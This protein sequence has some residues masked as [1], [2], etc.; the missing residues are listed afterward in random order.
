MTCMPLHGVHSF[1]FL[2]PKEELVCSDCAFLLTARYL[3][4]NWPEDQGASDPTPGLH[5]S[6][7]EGGDLD[8]IRQTSGLNERSHHIT[9]LLLTCCQT[10]WLQGKQ[11]PALHCYVVKSTKLWKIWS[12]TRGERKH[13]VSRTHGSHLCE[14]CCLKLNLLNQSSLKLWRWYCFGML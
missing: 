2:W 8:V 13:L 11:Q 14:S 1:R 9:Q 3:E 4:C 10:S 5:D 7:R 12:Q 6:N